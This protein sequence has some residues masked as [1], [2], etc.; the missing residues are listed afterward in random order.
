MYKQPSKKPLK[1]TGKQ[2]VK[3][4]NKFTLNQIQTRD[5]KQLSFTMP[6]T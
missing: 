5:I 3:H 4:L 6:E 1:K 2:N